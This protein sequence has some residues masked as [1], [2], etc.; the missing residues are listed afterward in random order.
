MHW[1]R[2]WQP[3]P[4]FSPGE[5]QG[6]GSL[7]GCHLWGRTVGHD[8]RD[9]AEWDYHYTHTHSYSTSHPKQNTSLDLK[10][11]IPLRYYPLLAPTIQ[12]Q[13]IL[14]VV[15]TPSPLIQYWTHPTQ[16]FFPAF[17]LPI[18]FCCYQTCYV[19]VMWLKQY[20][21]SSPCSHL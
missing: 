3:T 12:L 2:K 8:W 17:L 4:V 20:V 6:R 13:S 16:V 18:D 1:R 7:V 11:Q 15:S 19:P 21:P 10:S 9:I 5:S 14:L